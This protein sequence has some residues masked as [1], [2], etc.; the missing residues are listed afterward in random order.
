MMRRA[1]GIHVRT[2][3]LASTV[4]LVSMTVRIV[5]AANQLPVQAQPAKRNAHVRFP[6]HFLSS[7][8][9]FLLK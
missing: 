2:V 9:I 4:P 7:N 8:D 6:V 1:L 5:L 3:R